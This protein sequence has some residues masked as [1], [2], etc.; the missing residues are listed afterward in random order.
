MVAQFGDNPEGMIDDEDRA[1]T[2]ESLNGYDHALTIF[3]RQAATSSR[4]LPYFFR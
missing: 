1:G 4:H 3:R 2:L